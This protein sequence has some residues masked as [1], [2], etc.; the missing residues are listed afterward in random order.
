MKSSKGWWKPKLETEVNEREGKGYNAH[1]SA[2]VIKT[3]VTAL[4]QTN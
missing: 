1:I 4:A 3:T 2:S